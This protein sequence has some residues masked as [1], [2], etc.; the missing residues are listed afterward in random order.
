MFTK[1]IGGIVK[2]N[3][4]GIIEE[5]KKELPKLI[6]EHKDKIPQYLDMAKAFALAQLNTIDSDESG[7][8]D[9]LEYGEDFEEAAGHLGALFNVAQRVAKRAQANKEQFLPSEVKDAKNTP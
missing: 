1:L 3:L 8:A 7:K 6:E 4:P 2:S 9:A 5:F